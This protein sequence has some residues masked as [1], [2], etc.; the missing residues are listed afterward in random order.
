MS[1]LVGM[2]E[3]VTLLTSKESM[4]QIFDAVLYSKR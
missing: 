2:T 4:K 3:A 1:C